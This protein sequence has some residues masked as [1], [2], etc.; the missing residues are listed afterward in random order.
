MKVSELEF[1]KT[2]QAESDT[3]FTAYTE[4]GR[5]TVLDRMTGWGDGRRDTETGFRDKIHELFW[6]ASGMFDIR[7]YP[8]LELEDAIDLIKKHANTC[9]GI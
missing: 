9:V 8:E 3:L 4:Y 5:I 1:K 2:K 7:D 6:L